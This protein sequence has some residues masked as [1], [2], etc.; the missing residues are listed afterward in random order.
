MSIMV[1]MWPWY[2]M[3]E[4]YSKHAG[5]YYFILTCYTFVSLIAALIPVVGAYTVIITLVSLAVSVP[6]VLMPNAGRSKIVPILFTMLLLVALVY[7]I[8][9]INDIGWAK[10]WNSLIALSGLAM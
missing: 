9:R 10:Y 8:I 4:Q 1:M 5:T 7:N 2:K 6:L 3:R